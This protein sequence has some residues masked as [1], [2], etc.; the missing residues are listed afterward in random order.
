MHALAHEIA[1]H[2]LGA[3][4]WDPGQGIRATV[5]GAAQFTA[6]VSGNTIFVSDP[7]M[8]PLRNLPVLACSF[9]AADDLDPAHVADAIGAAMTRHDVADG[10]GSFALAFPWQGDPSHARLHAAARGIRR[11]LPKAV[12]S[13]Q[14]LVLMIDGD[15]GQTLGRII[16]E[17]VAPTADIV[18][19]D[20]VQLRAFD[21]VD[22]GTI[23]RPANVVTVI[24]KSLLF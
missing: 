20:G 6:Q 5:T 13:G 3:P 12:A 8:L 9:G 16:C 15:I 23:L 17:E 1:D 24:I 19:L 14:P 4:V 22:V 18:S 21:Y 7:D 2:G 10:E 11:A